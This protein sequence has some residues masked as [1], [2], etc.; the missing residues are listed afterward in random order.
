MVLQVNHIANSKSP[1]GNGHPEG[2]LPAQGIPDKATHAD[3]SI[4]RINYHEGR[5]SLKMSK[6]ECDT[7]VIHFTGFRSP[8]PDNKIEAGG[9]ICMPWSPFNKVSRDRGVAF[10]HVIPNSFGHVPAATAWSKGSLIIRIDGQ[11]EIAL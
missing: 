10:V 5:P 9:A 3:R 8:L 1:L 7:L 6:S 4:R 11:F 2:W